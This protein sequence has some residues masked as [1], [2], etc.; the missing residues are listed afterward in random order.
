MTP[1]LLFAIAA[2]ALAAFGT[3]GVVSY[4]EA[5]HRA[6]IGIRIPL[7]AGQE[8][9]LRL[10]LRQGM[11]PVFARLAA[12]ALAAV[13]IGSYVSS[14]LFEVVRTIPWRSPWG[15]GAGRGF[16][17]GLLDSGT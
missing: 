1:V 5:R 2:L 7:G 3:Y 9:V 6:K 8:R 13:A 12:G 11:T 10:V 4:A 16:G 15:C 17:I 14:L